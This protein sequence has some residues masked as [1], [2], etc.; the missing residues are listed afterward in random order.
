M[1]FIIE[2]NISADSGKQK[3]CFLTIVYKKNGIFVF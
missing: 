2:K 1:V 3:R